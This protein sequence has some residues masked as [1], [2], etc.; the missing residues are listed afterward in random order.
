MNK[1][2]L[3]F[4]TG[5]LLI[6]ICGCSNSSFLPSGNK[7]P[8][9]ISLKNNK[10]HL[11][12][13]EKS[14][15]SNTSNKFEISDTLTFYL[16]S[17]TSID[18]RGKIDSEETS[19]QYGLID[20]NNY[21]FLKYTFFLKNEGPTTADYTLKINLTENKVTSDGRYLDTIARVALYENDASSEEHNFYV[22]ARASEVANPVYDEETGSPTGEYT[23]KEY[24]SYDNP[25]KAEAYGEKFPG[26]AEMFESNTVITTRHH[27]GMPKDDVM[28]YTAVF[29][30]EGEDQQAKGQPPE[31]GSLKF[32]ITVD[33]KE[34]D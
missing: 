1:K 26:Y 15:F 13:S 8:F 22:Y 5:T 32:S 25:Q 6:N 11:V 7:S 12:M 3:S 27:I 19:Y 21:S 34:T 17:F 2:L 33:A 9:S 24:I 28:R 14:S 10:T 29:W 4:I 31:D 23:F 18:M 20:N 16:Y 30:L